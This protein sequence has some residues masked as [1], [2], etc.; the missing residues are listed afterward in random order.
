M[1]PNQNLNHNPTVHTYE[2]RK[3]SR[4]AGQVQGKNIQKPKKKEKVQWL[5]IKRNGL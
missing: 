4:V 3:M 2:G 1:C 5:V